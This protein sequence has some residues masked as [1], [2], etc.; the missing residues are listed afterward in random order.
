MSEVST[1]AILLRRVEYGDYDLIC[2]FFSLHHG[3]ISLMAKSAKRS[4]KRFA[5][6]LEPFSLIQIVYRTGQKKGL[7]LLQEASSLNPYSNIRTDI[8]KTAYAAYMAE[9]IN[10]WMEEKAVSASLFHLFTYVLE[11]IDEGGL[12]LDA[13]SILFQMRFVAMSGLRPNLTRCSGCRT[14]IE[15]LKESR[16]IFDLKKGGLV[17]NG[18]ETLTKSRIRLSKGT[19]KQLLWL[20][21]GD[22]KKAARIRFS[23]TALKEGLNFLEAFVPFHLGKEPKSLN[24][25]Q[26][27]RG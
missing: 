6:I 8:K 10:D 18:C 21:Q 25:I 20:E 12:S 14:R 5:G 11:V 19:I 27:L 24:F 23:P 17:C 15:D 7:P 22:L 9:L 3:K 13:V 26:Q 4:K 2:T 1:P 16:I